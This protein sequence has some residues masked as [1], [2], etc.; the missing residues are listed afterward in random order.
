MEVVSELRN[1]GLA[2]KRG[3]RMGAEVMRRAEIPGKQ[4]HVQRPGASE[5]GRREV[6]DSPQLQRSVGRDQVKERTRG[7]EGL[8]TPHYH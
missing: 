2:A 8:W 3:Q 6:K 1:E 4:G 7:A 5:R